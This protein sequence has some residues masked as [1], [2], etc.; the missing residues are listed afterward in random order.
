LILIAANLLAAFWLLGMP[1]V[2]TSLGFRP[3]APTLHAAVTCLFLHAN[4]IHLLGNMVFLAAV[5]AAV[6]MASGSLRFALVYFASGLVGVLAH[7]LM[8]RHATD[9]APFI[10]AS[11]CIAGCA[12]YYSFRYTGLK[13]PILPGK[14]VSV[15][16]V[17]GAWVV[18]QIVGAFVR[19]GD[20]EGTSFWAHLGGFAT[21]IVLSMLFRA[22]D[23]GQAKISHDIIDKM[24]DRGPAAVAAAAQRHLKQ[25]PN[26]PKAL[27]D[28]ARAYGELDDRRHEGDTL[29]KLLDA[30]PEE[31]QMAV[32]HRIE[33]IGGIGK[34]P[35]MRRLKFAERYKDTEPE[36]SRVLL[37]SVLNEAESSQKPEAMLSLA[38]LER[39]EHPERAEALLQELADHYPLHPAMDVARKRGW[40]S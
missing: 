30:S 31:K 9:P 11:G 29:L 2:R 37:E 21:G 6:E 33:A 34:L 15:A 8:T 19:L 28:L 5:G 14:E 3:N 38:A 20:T 39:D 24:S 26:D 36:L 17:T 27:D 1:E 13:V 18:L 10:G 12:G 7:Y 40:V 4:V 35:E 22:P 32:L 16:V 23:L 25:H